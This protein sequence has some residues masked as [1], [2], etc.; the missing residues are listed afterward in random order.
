MLSKAYGYHI[1][2]TYQKPV[3]FMYEGVLYGAELSGDDGENRRIYSVELIKAAPGST[4]TA[5]G[6]NLTNSL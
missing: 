2:V 1:H 5:A 4:L 3:Q 6:E